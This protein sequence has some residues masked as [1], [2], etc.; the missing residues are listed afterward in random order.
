[1]K[2][3]GL[4]T[5]ILVEDTLV[6]LSDRGELTLAKPNHFKFEELASFQVLSGKQNWTPPTY[7]NGRMHCR[8]SQ[9]N[10]VCLQMG[11]QSVGRD[12]EP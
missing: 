2:G 5:V 6:I 3:F 12:S 7:A 10:W 9:G 4:G 8:S 1:M 11:D